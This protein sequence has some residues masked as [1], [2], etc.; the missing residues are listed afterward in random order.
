M[1]V[2][3]RSPATSPTGNDDDDEKDDDARPSDA[4]S[5]QVRLSNILF[6][7]SSTYNRRMTRWLTCL[8]FLLATR[9]CHSLFTS[10]CFLV[11]L[12]ANR[13]TLLPK[14]TQIEPMELAK[15]EGKHGRVCVFDLLA[16]FSSRRQSINGQ[17]TDYS[18]L[19]GR[20]AKISANL[21][22]VVLPSS[23]PKRSVEKDQH[24]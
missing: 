15:G 3:A 6:Y 24:V 8:L 13:V 1:R 9:L 11:V 12:V 14:M 2:P 23:V 7:Q 10:V 20:V 5:S 19:F 21:K 17:R 22:S 18:V 4:T 16:R